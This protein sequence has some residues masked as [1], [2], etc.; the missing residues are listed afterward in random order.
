MTIASAPRTAARTPFDPFDWLWRL[1]QSIPLA[2]VLIGLTA[3]AGLLGAVFPQAPNVVKAD[4]VLLARWVAF[5]RETKYGAWTGAING[6]GLFDVFGQPWF[7]G[8]LI[9]LV[10]NIV[11]CT[12]GRLP[13][14]WRSLNR[15]RVAMPESFFA[16]AKI[17]ADLRTSRPAAETADSL[18]RL[19]RRRQYKV[20]SEQAAGAIY[21]YGDRNGVFKL[22]TIAT[23]TALIIFLFGVLLGNL[24]GWADETVALRDGQ[25]RPVGHGSDLTVTNE[26][27]LAE[28]REDGKP[29][30]FQTRLAVSR[31]G[32][33]IAQ[34]AITINDPLV[35]DGVRFHQ[36]FYG[37]TV[38]IE[39]QDATGRAA[40]AGPVWV[41]LDNSDG[42]FFQGYWQA[43]RADWGL[44][45]TMGNLDQDSML[46]EY[47]VGTAQQPSETRTA[48]LNQPTVIRDVR[49]TP[50]QVARFSGLRVASDPGMPLIWVAALLLLTGIA[51]SFY[52][53]RRRLWARIDADGRLRLGGLTEKRFTLQAELDRM[54]AA[55]G[56]ADSSLERLE[57]A[58]ELPAR[59]KDERA[60]DKELEGLAVV[61]VGTPLTP[62]PP[63]PL[64]GAGEKESCPSGRNGEARA[65]ETPLPQRNG[66]G[67]GGE[68]PPRRAGP[69]S[70]PKPRTRR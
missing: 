20:R 7:K 58:V 33:P 67:A 26:K 6:L 8:L 54:V 50:R 53:I 46:V 35:V 63:R 9:L 23:H 52:F 48:R 39:V 37:P 36:A 19:L 28:F 3:A 47:F 12:A 10:V 44:M 13:T 15:Y 38:Q 61:E 41:N 21:L 27:F 60:L 30:T 34:K 66:R 5:Q 70:S 32:Q 11:V 59:R 14:I 29:A 24:F 31:A 43:P 56:H 68:G 49:V 51:S 17:G 55:L 16:R 42:V 62:R 69:S 65:H 57:R 64:V 1:L 25:S 22:G 2:L 18:T 45:L 4:P 40:V